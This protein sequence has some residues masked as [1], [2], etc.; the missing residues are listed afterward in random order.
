MAGMAY[1]P[2]AVSAAAANAAYLDYKAQDIIRKVAKH[3][4]YNHIVRSINR[5]RM[6]NYTANEIQNLEFWLIPSGRHDIM[7]FLANE[8]TREATK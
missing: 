1:T 7:A 6:S 8:W 3:R 2:A 4:Y 5:D